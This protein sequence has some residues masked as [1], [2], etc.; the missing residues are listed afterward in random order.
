MKTLYHMNMGW[1]MPL[2]DIFNVAQ[3]TL[4]FIRNEGLNVN[5]SARQSYTCQFQTPIAPIVAFRPSQSCHG[6]VQNIDMFLGLLSFHSLF[7][8]GCGGSKGRLH[9]PPPYWSS[10]YNYSHCGSHTWRPR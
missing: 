3:N 8:F 1:G 7:S 9:R 5:L 10:R 6:L 2:W 4:L